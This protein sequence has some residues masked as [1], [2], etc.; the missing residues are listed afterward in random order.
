MGFCGHKH[1][2]TNQILQKLGVCN[3]SNVCFNI[4]D[5]FNICSF[6][7]YGNEGSIHVMFFVDLFDMMPC[8]F[9]VVVYGTFV[10]VA[11]IVGA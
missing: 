1:A 2:G 5:P 6:L 11:K 4:F 8:E 10:Y 7:N 9:C 3:S